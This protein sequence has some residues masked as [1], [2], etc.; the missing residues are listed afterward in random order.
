MLDLD[1]FDNI[2]LRYGMNDQEVS[3]LIENLLEEA[4]LAITSVKR[5]QESLRKINEKQSSLTKNNHKESL[6]LAK[7]YKAAL[8]E[9]R[10]SHLMLTLIKVGVYELVFINSNEK[11]LNQILYQ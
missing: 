3:L 10:S 2:F 6:R 8:V 9:L 7:E 1:E 4:K 11:D 5:H